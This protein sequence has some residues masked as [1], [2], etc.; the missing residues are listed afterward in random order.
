MVY[1]RSEFEEAYN[2]FKKERHS[3]T[4]K[5]VEFQEDTLM[6]LATHARTWSGGMKG[7]NKPV[8]RLEY[9]D[10]VQQ[11]RDKEEHDIRCWEKAVSIA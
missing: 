6:A 4:V 2:K 3:F 10:A 5:I 9:I 11:G 8:E 7:C 1:L